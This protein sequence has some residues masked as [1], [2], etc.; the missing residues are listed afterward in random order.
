VILPN[1]NSPAADDA[2]A[3]AAAAME[4]TNI[5]GNK[6]SHLILNIAVYCGIEYTDKSVLCLFSSASGFYFL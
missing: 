3:D 2:D 4:S 5:S 1:R 6:Y